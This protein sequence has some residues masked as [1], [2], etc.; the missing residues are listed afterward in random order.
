MMMNLAINI[1]NLSVSYQDQQVLRNVDLEIPAGKRIGILGPNGAGKSTLI[2]AILN[3]TPSNYDFLAFNNQ[4]FKEYKKQI[5]YVPQRTT[6]DWD[7]PIS[8]EEVVMMG[9]YGQLGLFKKPQKKD[10]M[11]VS[12]V[13]DQVNLTDYRKKQIGALSG[14]QQQRTFIARALAQ[15]AEIYFMDEPF[16]GVDIPTEKIIIQQL[17][18]LSDQGKTVFIVHHDLNKAHEYFDYIILLNQTVIAHGPFKEVWKRQLLQKC[19]GGGIENL[20]EFK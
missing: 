1:K 13:I 15:E 19:F 18:N 14:G 7:F 4:S 11:I 9:R 20:M 10:H 8:L 2:K 16:V 6:I 5:A 12:E 3:L 17:K